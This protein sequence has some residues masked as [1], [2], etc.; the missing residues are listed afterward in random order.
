MAVYSTASGLDSTVVIQNRE[1]RNFGLVV[2]GLFG[3]VFGLLLPLL[4]HRPIPWWPWVLAAL[5][6]SSALLRPALLYH[7]HRAWN[8]LGKILGWINTRL[9]LG[10]LFY[11]VVTPMGLVMRVLGYFRVQPNRTPELD[12]YRIES[13]QMNR[14][15]FERPF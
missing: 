12:S 8:E 10:L 13:R 9:I 4:H 7:F 3:G 14:D 5:L 6:T 2:G 1:L 15:S 11:V